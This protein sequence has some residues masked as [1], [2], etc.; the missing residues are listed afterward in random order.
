MDLL[1]RRRLMMSQSSGEKIRFFDYLQGDGV[2]YIDINRF[3]DPEPP[4][5]SRTLEIV[6]RPDT[7]NGY[8]IGCKYNNEV[9][10]GSYS[11][12]FYRQAGGGAVKVF[13]AN[14]Y[15]DF[16]SYQADK[17]YYLYY[18][19]GQ[20]PNGQCYGNY[21]GGNIVV[22]VNGKIMMPCV[23]TVFDYPDFNMRNGEFRHSTT[24][25]CAGKVWGIRFYETES[26]IE[27]MKLRPC[28]YDGVPGL[29]DEITGDFYGNTN[30]S[31]VLTVGND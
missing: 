3:I 18:K 1:L 27:L 25:R 26:G 9:F 22:I 12:G 21:V 31:G 17:K 16:T 24:N 15:R 13:A 14:E 8:I 20:S 5:P 23:F 10:Y 30:S 11:I 28:L 19:N 4:A 7:L 2:A 6:A 29:Y